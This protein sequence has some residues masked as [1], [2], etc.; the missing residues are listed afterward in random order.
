MIRMILLGRTGNNI[1]QYALGRVL[2][3]KHGV[4]LVMDGSW[5][6][7]KG[8]SEVSHFLKTPIK[9]TVRRQPSFASRVLLKL[10]GKHYWEY[11]DI[12]LI[13][14]K[15][16]D[17]RFDPTILEAPADCM[18]FGYFQSPL[19]FE[20]IKDELRSE[21]KGLL[22]TAVVPDPAWVAKLSQENAVAVHVR[23]T[24]Y[25]NI[26]AHQVCGESYHET[27]MAKL[28]EDLGSPRFHIFSDDPAW[29]RK[30]FTMPDQEIIDTSSAAANPLND[31]QLMSLAQ[32]HIIMNSTYSWWAAWLGE[33]PGQ[34]VIMPDRWFSEGIHA[35]ITEK[36]LPH[37]KVIAAGL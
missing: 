21:L 36:M 24:D 13:R 28:R 31:L 33:K 22:A 2:A 17:H 32:H 3:E 6:A 12:P 23:R 7:A 4:P 8:W 26:P 16:A 19:Y 15:P 18:I 29:C 34:T 10:T 5:F 30:R 27:A 14:E 25:L 1:F 20:S 11:R 37:W 9:A 35:P